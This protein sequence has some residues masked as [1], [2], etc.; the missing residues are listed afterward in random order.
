MRHEWEVG[1]E[2]VYSGIDVCPVYLKHVY[3]RI[4]KY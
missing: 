1:G 4:D 2:P 3:V